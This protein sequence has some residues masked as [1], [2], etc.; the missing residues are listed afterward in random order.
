MMRVVFALMVCT[1]ALAE[2]GKD[3]LGEFKIG[4]GTFVRIVSDR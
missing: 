1:P 3:E 2:E 4:S